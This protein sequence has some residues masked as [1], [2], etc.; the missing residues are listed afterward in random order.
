MH[1]I[2]IYNFNCR[3][4]F[5]LV[6]IPHTPVSSI[7]EANRPVSPAGPSSYRRQ[8]ILPG[9]AR[10]AALEKYLNEWTDLVGLPTAQIVYRFIIYELATQD[11]S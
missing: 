5:N 4:C 6:I 7:N 8:G 11:R 10:A 2:T 1:T 9:G 3:F